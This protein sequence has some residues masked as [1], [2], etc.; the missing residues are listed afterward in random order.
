MALTHSGR[1]A[2]EAHAPDL[3]HAQV[4][5]L[6]RHGERDLD[7]AGA[8]G[9][10]AERARRRRMAVRADERQA[11][12]AEALHMD[13]VADAVARTAVPHAEAPTGAAQEQVLVRIHV[14]VLDEVVI[15]VLRRE[16][17]L[18]PLDA[19]RLQF[20]HHQRA[21]HI[22]Q[23]RLIDLQRDFAAGPHVAVEKVRL[24]QLLRDVEGHRFA[25]ACRSS[26]LRCAALSTVA[27]NPIR[28]RGSPA[29]TSRCLAR[30]TA[31]SP[32]R[33]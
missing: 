9:Q 29:A 5:R 27:Q 15:D 2:G 6:A 17:D 20:E 25:L 14:I 10:H 8:E 33:S 22:L 13:R 11:R 23:Q 21:Q 26:P 12:L 31:G 4:Q 24:D 32:W 28:M 18:D 16:P 7:A 19:H 3:R 1:R 30:S